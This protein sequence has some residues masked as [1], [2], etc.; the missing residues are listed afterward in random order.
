M[1]EDSQQVH[2]HGNLLLPGPQPNPPRIQ[3]LKMDVV[4]LIDT[5]ESSCAKETPV[6]PLPMLTPLPDPVQDTIPES[7]P[8]TVDL[9]PLFVS[10]P[11]IPPTDQ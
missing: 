8:V 7:E 9:N 2:A 11:I 5:A 3:V 10:Q 1:K 6:E 4:T